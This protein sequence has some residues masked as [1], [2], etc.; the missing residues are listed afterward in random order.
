MMSA[1]RGFAKSPA[2]IALFGL[3][4]L[5]FA[6]WGVRDMFHTKISDWVV[7]AGSREISAD[8]Y[9]RI[10]QNQLQN[11]QQQNGGQAITAQDAAAHGVD[12][13]ILQQLAQQETLLEA[14]RRSGVVPSPQLVI[15]QLRK[16]PAFFNPITGA[17]DEKQYQTRL[18][19]A[20]LTPAMFEGQMKDQISSDHFSEGVGAGLRPPL[21]YA[22][23]FAAI[24]QQSRS[25]DYFVV[26]PHSVEQPT[27]PTDADLQKL[28]TDHADQLRR[29][30]T[31]TISLVRFSAAALAQTLKADP[32]EVQKQFDFR[33][34]NLSVP[35]RRSF[36]QVPAK[37]QAQAVAIAARL[38][39]G[40]DP[41]AVAKSYGVKPLNF[42]AVPKTAVTDP[43]IGDAAF[44]LQAGQVSGPV[45]GEFGFAVVKLQSITPAKPASLEDVRPQI[46]QEVNQRAAEE[47]V[48]DQVQ[49]Y[50]DSHGSGTP[51]AQAAKAAG[52]EM[53]SL[54]PMTADGRTLQ[55]QPVQGLNQKM[56][57]DAFSLVQGGET[58]VVDLGKGEYYAIRA[59]KVAPPSLPSLDE[60][61]PQLT[62]V[63]MQQQ[64][65]QRVSAK[66][67]GLIQ[68]IKKGESLDAVAAS[69]GATVQHTGPLTRSKVQQD[70]QLQGSLGQDFLGRLFQAKAGD[71]FAASGVNF[72]I[73]VVKVTQVQPGSV[74]QIAQE[75]LALQPQ[76]AQQMAQGDLAEMV[77]T[78]ASAKI[79]P[80]VDEVRA[81]QAIGVQPDQTPAS[82]APAAKPGNKA[83]S[84]AQ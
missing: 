52:V 57:T 42:A 2:A 19:Q 49:K 32:A 78:A 8:Q 5:S 47:K 83:S 16:I 44:K 45:Q 30:E 76:I 34:G 54:G 73:A 59:D 64:V 66:A 11:L 41:S 50:E 14:I 65:M 43:R 21:T 77:F 48:Y 80:K 13:Q 12:R 84:K 39:K 67:D 55:G 37:D 58:D 4:I 72:S 10:F 9:K 81:K 15:D 18:A 53:F 23:V 22:A 7:S 51:M 27:K 28:I 31:R 38:G 69:A 74:Q 56:V 75:A 82:G 40:E 29:P 33:K 70:R 6:I 1:F 68:R 3:L 36:V 20:E 62:Q 24:A 17:F 60:I 63:Y 71:A 46:E 79:K 35:E 26:D 61:R 25:A